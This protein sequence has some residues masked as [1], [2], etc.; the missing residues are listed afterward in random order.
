MAGIGSALLIVSGLARAAAGV[1]VP[2]PLDDALPP[3]FDERMH[4]AAGTLYV[5]SL[6]LAVVMWIVASMTHPRPSIWF[7]SYSLVTVVAAIAAPPAL[8]RAGIATGHDVGLFQRALL[9]ALNAWIL[10]FACLTY[11]TT[12]AA[13][14]KRL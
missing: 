10:V 3:S 11:S 14:T 13:P 2:D 12:L 4:N 8:L 9:G 5:L 1:F 7:A 6:I